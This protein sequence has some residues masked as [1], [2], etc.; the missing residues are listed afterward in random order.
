M[1]PGG[2]AG[3]D[4]SEPPPADGSCFSTV[5]KRAKGTRKADQ[6][7][8]G[9]HRILIAVLMLGTVL[10]ASCGGWVYYLNGQLDNVARVDLELD[11]SRRP[12]KVEGEAKEALNILLAGADAGNGPSIEEAVTADEWE[13][14]S[15][16][17]DTIM[18]L[19]ITAER[20]KAYLVSVPRDSWVEI[21]GYGESK[22]NAAFSRGGPSLYV[23]TLEEFTGLRMDHLAIIDWEGFRELTTAI[24]GVPVLIPE[25]IYDPSQKVQWTAGVQDLEGQRALQYVRMRYGLEGGDFDRIARQQNFLRSFMKKMLSNGTTGNPVKLTNAVEAI[26]QYLT[27][28]SD[29]ENSD[30]RGLALSLRSLSQQ[31]VVFMTV[32]MERYDNING[33]SVVIIDEKRKRKLFRAV[34]NDRLERYIRRFGTEN[35]LDEAGNIN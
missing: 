16:R 2:D 3:R 21:P 9:R 4:S 23:Q 22:I 5:A 26:V 12:E 1:R 17:S 8:F 11:D 10:L 28:D 30:I 33:Q 20:D 27:V 25:D 35:V 24:G 31:D 32:P 34:A 19:H 13:P 7:W 6:S 15:H 14:G 29:F 18:V